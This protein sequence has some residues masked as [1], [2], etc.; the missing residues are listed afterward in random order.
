MLNV[1][2]TNAAVLLLGLMCASSA[3]ALER[4]DRLLLAERHVMSQDEAAARVR[5]QTGGRVL[6]IRSRTEDGRPVYR[7]KVLLSDGRVRILTINAAS[8]DSSSDNA[9]PPDRR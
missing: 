5:E 6:D 8:G 7:V 2:R 3:A 1:I 4:H 9:D